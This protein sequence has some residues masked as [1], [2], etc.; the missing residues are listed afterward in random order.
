LTGPDKLRADVSAAEPVPADVPAEPA[1]AV[2][3]EPVPE[4]P[5]VSELA[6]PADV[7]PSS[8]F[9]DE[10]VA[11]PDLIGAIPTYAEERRGATPV[12]L[13]RRRRLFAAAAGV[14]LLIGA[15]AAF[16]WFRGAGSPATGTLSVGTSPAG[17]AVFVDG[18][19][20]GV[21]PL[22]V[23]LPPGEH[24]IE[25]R[26]ETERRRIPITLRAG[27]QVSQYF[28]F[29]AA[30][31]TIPTGELLVRTEPIGAA[32]TVDGKYAGRS[33]VSVSDLTPGTHTVVMQNDVGTQ[34]ERVIIENGRTASL[35]VSLGAVA[36]K[37]STAGWIRLDAPAEIQVLE[38]GR[39]IGSTDLERV[40]LPVGR[41]DLEFVNTPLGYRERRTVQV[42]AGQTTTLRPQWPNGSMAINASPWAEVLVD[43]KR[44]GETPIG[45]ITVPIGAHEV[46]FR[47][48]ELGERRMSVTVSVGEP[49]KVGVDL[50]SK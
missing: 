32:V 23:E 39:V 8:P 15:I 41:H 25:L 47:H 31:A 27:G 50:R 2:A 13:S 11:Q 35:V 38:D 4:P 29:A 12:M 40:M 43:N 33:P 10:D 16:W 42:T 26:T 37:A 30:G 17:I 48:P 46:L 18:Q 5:Y 45:N 24:V 28:E 44:V 21:T 14:V 3:T 6:Q 7:A 20:H 49:L 36:N 34:T 9:V 22:G 19:A 1:A